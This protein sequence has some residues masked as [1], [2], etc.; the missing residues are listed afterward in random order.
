MAGLLWRTFEYIDEEMFMTL[1]KTMVRSHLEY[2]APV[3][4]PHTWKLAEELE[5]VQ[6]R[7]TKRIP[8]LANLEYEERLRQLKLPTLV[9]RRLRGDMINVYKYLNKIYDTETCL[10]PQEK[11]DR[12]RGHQKKLRKQHTNT[13]PRH[14]FFT[15]RVAEWWNKLPQEVISAPSVNTFKNR[16]DRH[17][18]SHPMKYDYKALD[19]PVSPKMTIT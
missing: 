16:L 4:S 3:W 1:Y 10:L 14:F 11:N 6:R 19:N 18:D 9:Y 12:T 8:S 2:A 15:Q 13:N 5:K 7:A 17:F